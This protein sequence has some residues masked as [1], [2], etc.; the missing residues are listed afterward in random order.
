[1]KRRTKIYLIVLLAIAVAINIG[2]YFLLVN[3]L[4]KAKNEVRLTQAQIIKEIWEKQNIQ[5]ELKV[6]LEQLQNLQAELEDTKNELNVA[7]KKL[8]SLEKVNLALVEEKENLQTKLSSIKELK[9]AIR[10]VKLQIHQQKVAR[11]LA[12]KKMQKEVDAQQLA[13]GNRGYMVKDGRSLSLAWLNFKIEVN[14]AY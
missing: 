8:G 11:Y 9:N 7:N 14:P 3:K 13:S 5:D 2:G 4:L 12:N 1:M 10:M 6:R